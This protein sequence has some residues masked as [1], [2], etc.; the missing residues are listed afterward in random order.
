MQTKVIVVMSPKGGVGKTTVAVNL[1]TAISSLKKKT[2]LIDANIDTPHVAVYYGFV[3]FK[4]SFEDLLNGNATIKDVIYTGDDPNFHILP[5]RV[6]ND[7]DELAKKK[8]VNM[9]KYLK[10]LEG[11]YDFIIIDSKPSYNID[12][13]EN[14]KNAESIIVSNPEITSIIEAKK[15]KEKL[16]YSKIDII[17]LIL[18]KV[19]TRIRE[20]V[21][22]KEAE[23]MTGIQ[24]IWRIRED[25]R[26]YLALKQ[27]IPIVTCA[28]KSPASLDIIN[29]AKDVIKM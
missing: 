5:S 18:N 4:Y 21:T 19:N 1:A 2:L 9:E 8:L 28:S 13:I 3:G 25:Q 7:T 27:G 16:D 23:D 29:I 15:I 24:N 20:Q 10:L 12:F 17:G 22:K 11:I 14:L 26:V 6:D